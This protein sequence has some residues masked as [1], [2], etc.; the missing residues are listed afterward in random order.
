[1]PSQTRWDDLVDLLGDD[2]AAYNRLAVESGIDAALYDGL[3]LDAQIRR[4]FAIEMEYRTEVDAAALHWIE[5]GLLP[6]VSPL[7]LRMFVSRLLNGTIVLGDILWPQDKPC[8]IPDPDR[9][10]SNADLLRWL[11]FAQWERRHEHLLKAIVVSRR[12]D[13][14]L[15][16]IFPARDQP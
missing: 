1:M 12:L 7:S 9:S 11:L 15:F 14:P 3:P 4:V 13:M 2:Y 10:T 16:G 6:D 8:M 5:N